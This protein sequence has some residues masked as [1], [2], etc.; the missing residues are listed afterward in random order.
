MFGAGELNVANSYRILDGGEYDGSVIMPTTAAGLY[1]YDFVQ[2]GDFTDPL[3]YRFD[4]DAGMRM[5]QFSVF[6]NWNIRVGDHPRPGF[7]PVVDLS[8]GGDLSNLTLS[9]FDT[10]DVLVDESVSGIDNFEHL[11][12]TDLAAG[13]YRLEVSLTAGDLPVDFG[14]AWRS[15]VTAVP[16]PESWA[17]LAVGTALFGFRRRVSRDCFMIS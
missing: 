11:Y 6:L 7:D 2:A 10:E 1:G 14:L 5:D 4:V 13:S 9:L 15:S 8:S 17:A 3:Q 12:V 16:E